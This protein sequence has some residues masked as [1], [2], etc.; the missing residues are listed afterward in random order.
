MPVQSLPPRPSLASVKKQAKQ[1]LRLHRNDPDSV[2]ARIQE[3]H[4]RPDKFAV[5]AD[6]QLVVAREY[7]FPS[8]RRLSEHVEELVADSR[9]DQVAQ[10]LDLACLTYGND[11]TARIDRAKAMLAAR[12]SLAEADAYAAAAT[13]NAGALRRLLDEDAGRV[14]ATGGPHNWPPLLYLCYSRITEQ[15]PEGDAVAAARLLLDRGADPN[16]HYMWDGTYRFTALTGAMGEGE[17]GIVSQPPHA[18]AW[19]LATLLLDAGADPN[20]AQGLYNTIF[21]PDNRWLKLLLERG[22]TAAARINWKTDNL[23][24]TLDFMLGHAATKGFTERVEL[25]LRHGADPSGVNYYDGRTHYEN[26]LLNGFGEIADMLVRAG[27]EPGEL[28][29]EHRFR[30]ACMSGDEAAARAALEEAPGSL[31][32]PGAL[33]AAASLGNTTAL[34]CLLSLGA[35]ANAVSEDGTTALHQAAWHDHRAAAELLIAHGARPLRDANHE[36]T[37]AG[38]ADHAGHAAMRDYLLDHCPDGFDLVSFGRIESLR[39]YLAEHPGFAT[40]TLPGGGTPLHHLRDDIDHLELVV[41]ALLAAGA[42]RAARDAKG[43]TA[44][45]SAVRR[46][47]AAVAALLAS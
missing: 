38:W 41:A 1:L 40:S 13:A 2:R 18:H 5:L 44:R 39:R 16:S 28:S 11:S 32:D 3:H 30:A 23:V 43:E 14:T 37:P 24:G 47:E 4:P 34:R 20:D 22:L 7:G 31:N 45:D 46:G 21:R 12:P 8:W 19:A 42:D 6:A 25:V 27:A 26:A 10:F 36:S 17:G 33:Q 15:L 29:A 35:D 9:D